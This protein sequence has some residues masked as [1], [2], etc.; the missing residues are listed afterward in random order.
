MK[1][2]LG[3]CPVATKIPMMKPDVLQCPGDSW[4]LGKQA[5]SLSAKTNSLELFR[6]LIF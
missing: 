2:D 3:F 5:G 6:N 4:W 1:G